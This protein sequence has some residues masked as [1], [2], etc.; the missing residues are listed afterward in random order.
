MSLGTHPNDDSMRSHTGRTQFVETFGSIYEHSPWVAETVWDSF[1]AQALTT[2][3]G[4]Q[5]AMRDVVDRSDDAAKLT[6][7]REHPDLADPAAKKG[8]LSDMSNREQKG[9]GLTDTTAE[10]TKRFED[11]NTAYKA[12][13]G[14]PFVIAVRG[15][16]RQ[17]IL[18]A[19][20]GR[21]RNDR[22]EEMVHAL[23]QIHRIAGFRLA[24]VFGTQPNVTSS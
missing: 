12:K 5:S 16:N 2:L 20:E 15:L 9:A 23:E 7:I 17:D 8:Q 1:D 24:D 14:F 10:E 19:F 21:L 22:K 11:L 18:S 3:D 4:L 13:F 6:L